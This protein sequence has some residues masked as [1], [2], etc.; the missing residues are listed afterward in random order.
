MSRARCNTYLTC[1]SMVAP[2]VLAMLGTTMMLA[3]L[4]FAQNATTIRYMPL[5][6]SITEHGCWR[7]QLF[8]KLTK[9]NYTVDFVG[10]ASSTTVCEVG[11]YDNNHEGHT[12][13]Q[14]S[15][16]AKQSQ[17]AGWLQSNPADLITMHLGTVD[18]VE[19]NITQTPLVSAFTNIVRQMRASNPKMKIIVSQLLFLQSRKLIAHE[20]LRKSFR[21]QL[22]ATTARSWL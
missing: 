11:S 2:N 5:G 9:A 13:N 21:G 19:G 4:A 8:D 18:I 22:V 17:L 1:S 15:N 7:A 16:I 3:S 10:S 6:D 14:A 20:R 12:G